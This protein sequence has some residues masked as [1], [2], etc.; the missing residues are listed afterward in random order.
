MNKILS[1]IITV[2]VLLILGLNVFSFISKGDV[3]LGVEGTTGLNNLTL[4]GNLDVAGETSFTGLANVS[5]YSYGG[6]LSIASTT[7]TALVLTADQVCDNGMISVLPG[8]VSSVTVTLPATTTL[9]STC[10]TDT[11]SRKSFLYR[12][13]ATAAT[14]T[15]IVAGAGVTLVGTATSSAIAATTDVITQ[16]GWAEVI[17]TNFG[18]NVFV[19]QI[20]PFADAD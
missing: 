8:G 3:V 10:L 5:T 17:L 2:A 14:S 16:N 1:Y 6:L 11:G 18:S 12:N 20:I 7:A 9:A 19:A 15:T 4:T 13:A